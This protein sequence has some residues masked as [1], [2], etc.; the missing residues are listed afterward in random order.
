MNEVNNNLNTIPT[1]EI[2]TALTRSPLVFV[3]V[4]SPAEYSAG[5]LPDAVNI[6]LFNDAERAAV[7]TIYK[8]RGKE[9]AKS[10]GLSL[11]SQKLP[12]FVEQFKLLPRGTQVIVYCWRGGMRSKTA[13]TLL[14]L[15]DMFTR[16]LIGGYKQYRAVVLAELALLQVNA[17]IVVLCGST[18]SGKTEL[19]V[20]LK[21]QGFAVIDL[22]RLANHRGSAFGGAGLGSM[23]T[24]H[25]FDTLLLAELKNYAA[26][27]YILVECE[28]KRI[29]NVYIPDCLFTKMATGRK[30]LL[31]TS[32]DIRT[33]RLVE[34]YTNSAE[35]DIVE[36]AASLQVLQHKL[37]KTTYALLESLLDNHDY[38]A[39]TRLL[40]EKYYDQLYG[41]ETAKTDAF[42]AVIA[43]ND[44]AAAASAVSTLI[45]DWYG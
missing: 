45:E 36:L 17:E 40:L 37:G 12:N 38:P 16:Q 9:I 10:Y 21:K 26:A 44:L 41:Y 11:F 19:L 24:A 22:E 14:G 33:D 42:A 20:E 28:S 43:G 18:G 13:V 39:F 23:Q 7:G 31:Q 25:N 34:E 3:D 5:R 30:I 6:P 4:R 2:E 1:I 27:K 15:A 32:I 8:T 35:F 29:G